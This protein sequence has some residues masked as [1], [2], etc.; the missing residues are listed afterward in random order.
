MLSL[1]HRASLWLG[2]DIPDVE[3]RRR[4][5]RLNRNFLIAAG[6]LTGL[7]ALS[8]LSA[9]PASA[10]LLAVAGL[11]IAIIL[12]LLWSLRLGRVRLTAYLTS[13]FL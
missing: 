1:L 8:L 2:P 3:D 11:A 13:A 12:A 7:R 4:I 10:P 9:W 6:L 5:T